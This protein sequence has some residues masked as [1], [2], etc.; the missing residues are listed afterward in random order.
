LGGDH[1]LQVELSQ[2]A[3]EGL[4]VTM[5]EG[6]ADFKAVGGGDELLAFERAA[7][8]VNE[9][10]GQMGDVA[11]GFVFDFAILA[12]GSAEKMGVVSRAF[13]GAPCSGYMNTTVSGW[14]ERMMSLIIKLSTQLCCFSGYKYKQDLPI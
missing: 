2:A 13:V 11:E 10:I 5:R 6:A 7:D 4:D 8:Q 9:R 3:Q 14:H 1:I 12:K